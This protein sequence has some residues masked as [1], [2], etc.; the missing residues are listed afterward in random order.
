MKAT[1]VTSFGMYP[2]EIESEKKAAELPDEEIKTRYYIFK[3]RYPACKEIIPVEFIVTRQNL[4]AGV[5][6]LKKEDRGG[7]L[8]DDM[9]DIEARCPFCNCINHFQIKDS[10]KEIS[11]RDYESEMK[12]THAKITLMNVIHRTLLS[13][14]GGVDLPK[15]E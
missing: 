9:A 13:T 2:S 11:H 7:G 4:S 8:S 15:T 14:D 10:I 1:Q 5:F 12:L 3:C 6:R